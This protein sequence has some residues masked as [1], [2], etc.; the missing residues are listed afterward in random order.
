METSSGHL[1]RLL[2][3]IQVPLSRLYAWSSALLLQNERT[4]LGVLFVAALTLRVLYLVLFVG[5]DSQPTYDGVGYDKLATALLQG[6]GYVNIYGEPTAFRPPIY[7]LFLSGIYA[8][9][10]HSFAAVRVTQA[11]LDAVTVVFC[12]LIAKEL[13]NKRV[14]LIASLG[15]TIYPLLIFET[16]EFYTETLS[17]F[18]QFGALWCLLLMLRSDRLFLPLLAGLLAGLTVLARPTAT[19]WVP[20]ILLWVLIPGM[21]HKS[22]AKLVVL[23]VGLG[24][25]FTPWIVRNSLV[26]NAFIPVSAGGQVGHWVCNNPFSDGGG[27]E[28]TPSTWEGSDYPTRS[29]YGWDGLSEIESAQRFVEAG[30]AW[31]RDHP[32]DYLLLIPKRLLRTWSPASF[33]VQLGRQA[34]RWLV[35][36]VLVPY[37]I[38]LALAGYGM[39]LTRNKWYQAFPLLAIIVSVNVL[40]IL[41]CGATR[42]GIPMAVTFIFFAGVSIDHIL[43]PAGAVTSPVYPRDV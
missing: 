20:L 40:V 2:T 12:Y 7:P 10:F 15:T 24:I 39:W 30:R 3:R 33:S 22:V 26:F 25:V 5:L 18:L 17:F 41:F 35:P 21:L 32:V 27:V 43:L 19:L 37:L 1:V 8:V 38:F 31:I 11:V 14:A 28:P 6:K 13:F 36:L 34:P 23:G 29:W 4:F 42:Y 9:T 16:G